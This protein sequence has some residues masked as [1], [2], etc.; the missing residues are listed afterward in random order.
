MKMIDTVELKEIQL[1]ILEEI[2]RFCQANSIQY[3]LFAGTLIGAV[4]HNGYIPWDDDIDICM[5]RSDYERF[6]STFNC[7][8]YS[9]YLSAICHENDKEYYLAAGKVVDTRTVLIEKTKFKHSIGVY[10]DVFP[11]DNLPA[12]DNKIKA[13]DSKLKKYRWMQTLKTVVPDSKRS[14]LK[15]LALYCGEILLRPVSISTI[16][17]KI[18]L[19][20]KTFAHCEN[21]KL[22][23]ISV[24]T[25]GMKEVFPAS[26]FAESCKLSFEGK[27][28]N[29]PIN[30]DD[31]LSRMYGDYMKLPPKEKQISH[32]VFEA[33]W[34]E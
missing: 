17:R 9:G 28:F 32:H 15:N 2:D 11:M 21:E 23:D 8:S 29:A 7:S 20:A 4:R 25:Y 30:Y 5:K 18:T 26:D 14:M 16:I 12:E 33:Y 13:L 3:F 27:K 10:V 22:A 34:K 6:F 31:V 24:F 1:Q 19:L